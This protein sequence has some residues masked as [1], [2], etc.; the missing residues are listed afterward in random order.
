MNERSF[1]PPSLRELT[2]PGVPTSFS[3]LPAPASVRQVTGPTCESCG[4]MTLS[5]FQLACSG[6]GAIPSRR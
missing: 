2:E 4:R 6:V 3:V 5:S 1:I